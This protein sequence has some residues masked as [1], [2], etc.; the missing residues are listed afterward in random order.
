MTII[1]V[2]V[3]AVSV[4][5]TPVL[6]HGFALLETRCFLPLLFLVY[7]LLL[8]LEREYRDQSERLVPDVLH[9][10]KVSL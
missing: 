9:G 5:S 8:S 3:V 1:L 7:S 4:S 2:V 6:G 10:V